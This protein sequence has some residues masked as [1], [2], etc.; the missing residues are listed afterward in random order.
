[1]SHDTSSIR[2]TRVAPRRGRLF[3]AN[4]Y[5]LHDVVAVGTQTE[6]A[7]AHQPMI[8]R[9]VALDLATGSGRRAPST[10]GVR[11]CVP[12]EMARLEHPALAKIYELGSDPNVGAFV[13]QEHLEGETLQERVQ[14]T[15]PLRPSDAIALAR[16]LLEVLGVFHDAGLTHSD[17][18]PSHIVS[19]RR[20]TRVRHHPLRELV[21][22]GQGPR[23]CAYNAPEQIMREPS[24]APTDLF[25]AAAVLYFAITGR[26]PFEGADLDAAVLRGHRA[27]PSA[28]RPELGG[29]VDAFFE[30]ALARDPADRFGTVSEMREALR[31]LALFSGYAAHG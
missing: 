3:L 4:K 25:R 15:G 7:A 5:Q 6:L 17:L 26:A 30:R 23:S 31:L 21:A 8:D 1:M 2:L 28:V 20:G 10:S 9:L 14:E 18:T 13:A 24:K 19:G 27:P 12:V 29:D 22:S 16:S 11:S